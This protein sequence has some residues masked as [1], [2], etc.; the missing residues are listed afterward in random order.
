M[1]SIFLQAGLGNQFF[2]L[3]TAIAYAIEFQETLVIPTFKWDVEKRQPYWDSVFKRLKD[4]LDPKLMPGSLPRYEEEGFH[5]TPLVKK[6]KVI[7]FGYFQS[8]RYFDR[9]SESIIKRLSLRLEQEMI[10]TKYLTLAQSI[11]LHFRIGDYMDVQLHHPLMTDSYYIDSIKRIIK[12][13]KKAD[14]DIIYFCEAKDNLPVRQ[15]LY[16]IQKQFPHL[17]F[18]KA[19]DEMQDWEQLLLMSCSDHNIIAN[20]TFSWWGA[21]LNPN[22]AKIVCYPSTWFGSANSDKDTRDLCPPQWIKI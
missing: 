4:A 14:W 18:H 13:T 15:R 1:I 10:K 2:Q 22:P 11:S 17:S 20:S 3:F 21:Y 12:V 5:Y 7:L 8:Y 9:Y 19:S 6:N 16:K